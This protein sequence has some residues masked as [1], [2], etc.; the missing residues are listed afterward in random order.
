MTPVRKRG[1]SSDSLERRAEG[2]GLSRRH[3]EALPA[4]AAIS[5]RRWMERTW[6]LVGRGISSPLSGMPTSLHQMS[7]SLPGHMIS[8]ELR[9]CSFAYC[10]G[11]RVNVLCQEEWARTEKHCEAAPSLPPVREPPRAE[12]PSPLPTAPSAL[13]SL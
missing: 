7:L 1:H 12:P 4:E 9:P 5:V 8:E 3:E 13:S 2:W 11:K 10:E 6:P